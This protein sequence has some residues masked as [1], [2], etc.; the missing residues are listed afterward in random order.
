MDLRNPT[1]MYAIGPE[2]IIGIRPEPNPGRPRP[3]VPTGP[4]EPE[5]PARDPDDLP[6]PR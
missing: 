5:G 2:T 6:R 3:P 4:P 1:V